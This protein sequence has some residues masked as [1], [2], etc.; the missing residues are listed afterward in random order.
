MEKLSTLGESFLENDWKIF[1]LDTKTI[2]KQVPDP[3]KKINV[4]DGPLVKILDILSAAF[5]VLISLENGVITEVIGKA[6]NEIR[7]N[8][9][10]KTYLNYST[11]NVIKVMEEFR[12]HNKINDFDETQC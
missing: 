5:E 10:K 9:F 4:I 2:L 3:T 11:K 8:L 1:N 12:K 6:Y 7:C